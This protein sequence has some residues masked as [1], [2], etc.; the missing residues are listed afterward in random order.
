MIDTLTWGRKRHH[1]PILLEV[2]VTDVRDAIH[3]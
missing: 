1:I 2:D 3:E